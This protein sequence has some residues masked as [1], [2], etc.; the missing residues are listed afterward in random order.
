MKRLLFQL[1]FSLP[2]AVMFLFDWTVYKLLCRIHFLR[3]CVKLFATIFLPL[4]LVIS[5]LCNFWLLL[6]LES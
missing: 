3:N 6:I 2:T 1:Q 4:F 5:L